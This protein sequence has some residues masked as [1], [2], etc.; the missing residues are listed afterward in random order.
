MWQALVHITHQASEDALIH[1]IIWKKKIYNCTVHLH[2]TCKKEKASW[3]FY[4]LY[5]N[6]IFSAINT[7]GDKICHD[8]F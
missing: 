2:P 3:T 5:A 1:V 7:E 6:E 4:S 8:K